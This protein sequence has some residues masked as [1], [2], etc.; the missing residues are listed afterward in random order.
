VMSRQS[1]HIIT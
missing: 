1:I